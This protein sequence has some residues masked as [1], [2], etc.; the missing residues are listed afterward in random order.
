MLKRKR[1]YFNMSLG[2]WLDRRIKGCAGHIRRCYLLVISGD[3]MLCRVVGA[4][5]PDGAAVD[6]ERGLLSRRHYIV[7]SGFSRNLVGSL[8]KGFEVSQGG[9]LG[10]SINRAA[11]LWIRAR[12]TVAGHARHTARVS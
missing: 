2:R 3:R 7:R 12:S 11:D 5:S 9:L 10:Q 1:S 8:R 6:D 4:A